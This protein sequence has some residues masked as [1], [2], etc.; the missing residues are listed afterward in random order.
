MRAAR[1]GSLPR[2]RSPEPF[3]FGCRDGDVGAGSLRRIPGARGEAHSG[4]HGQDPLE[5]EQLFSYLFEARCGRC[6]CSGMMEDA[7]GMLLLEDGTLNILDTSDWDERRAK[8]AAG[9]AGGVGM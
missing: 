1:P 6:L 2:P 9:A 7:T 3:G 5:L 8:M 4:G